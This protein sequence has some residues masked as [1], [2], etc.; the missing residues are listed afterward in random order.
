MTSDLTPEELE[1]AKKKAAL[2][3][4]KKT[5]EG[6]GFVSNEEEGKEPE[7][8]DPTPKDPDASKEAAETAKAKAAV[9]RL[10]PQEHQIVSYISEFYWQEKCLP[11]SEKISEVTKA[12][13]GRVKKVLKRPQVIEA[14]HARGIYT[15]D[16]SGAYIDSGQLTAQQTAC[17]DL[18]LNLEDKR[19]RREKLKQIG[20]ST[21]RFHAWMN[22]PAFRDYMNNRA[23]ELFGAHEH[24]AYLA[25]LKSVQAGSLEAAKFYLELSGI[26]NP[27]LTVQVDVNQIVLQV[28]EIVTRRVR[29]VETVQAIANDLAALSVGTETNGVSGTGKTPLAL[30]E[31]VDAEAENGYTIRGVSSRV[32]TVDWA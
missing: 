30:P 18:M 2:A 27:K 17:V 32:R 22:N 26:Y 16:L 7:W 15:E 24:D 8:A 31:K 13:V 11:S 4:H 9:A 20:V 23:K 5:Y 12:P 29:D 25:V 14:L 6:T 19:S 21:A 3:N 10:T 28:V 1:E